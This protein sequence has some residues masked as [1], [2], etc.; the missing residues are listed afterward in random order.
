MPIQ[1]TD[2]RSAI[3][4]MALQGALRSI[5]NHAPFSHSLNFLPNTVSRRPFVFCY[6]H[7]GREIAP[8]MRSSSHQSVSEGD[9]CMATYIAAPNLQRFILPEIEFDRDNSGIIDV[10]EE[11][12]E[13]VM[14]AHTTKAH[15]T[16]KS[17]PA[18][19]KEDLDLIPQEEIVSL[20]SLH[21]AYDSPETEQTAA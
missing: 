18:S 13:R 17:R 15:T 12:V 6:L 5:R 14:R 3:S 8:F 7:I 19:R 2:A 21:S 4:A 10:I 1:A 20:L 11:V 16:K 9:F